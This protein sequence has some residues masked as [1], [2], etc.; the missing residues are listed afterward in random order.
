MCLR[1]LSESVSCLD[2]LVLM[3]S[4]TLRCCVCAVSVSMCGAS[5]LSMCVCP[6][7]LQCGRSVESPIETSGVVTRLGRGLSLLTVLTVRLQVCRQWLVLVRAS[8]VLL[9]TLKERWKWWLLGL[10]E[11]DRVL[12]TACFTMNRRFTTCT[13]RCMLS[14]TIGLLEWVIRCPKVVYGPCWALLLSWTSELAS[15]RF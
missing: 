6:V 12:V 13:V 1:T 11:C 5:L 9:S 15:T 2:L 8:V 10:C 3:A 14:W 4:V 7:I